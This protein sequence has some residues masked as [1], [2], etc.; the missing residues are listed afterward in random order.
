MYTF[1]LARVKV[2]FDISRFTAE[3]V[4]GAR[5][6]GEMSDTI[7]LFRRLGK[8][9]IFQTYQWP[10]RAVRF[11]LPVIAFHRL[12]RHVL[13]M[14]CILNYPPA[15]PRRVYAAARVR[16]SFSLLSPCL[17]RA[18]KSG[19]GKLK[20]VTR[21]ELLDDGHYFRRGCAARCDLMA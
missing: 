15:V 17:L 19:P 16:S 18:T 5:S 8:P 2:Y 1:A 4:G 20:R 7:Q 6:R 10:A 13:M 3:L 11:K 21:E 14:V 12:E 9:L